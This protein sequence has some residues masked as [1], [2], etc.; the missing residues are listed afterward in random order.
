MSILDNL[1]VSCCI[2]LLRDQSSDW[3]WR[4][5][6]R[7][8]IF[9]CHCE[10]ASRPWQ[11]V[12]PVPAPAGA[13][14]Q[15]LPCVKAAQCSHWVVRRCVAE[16]ATRSVDGGIVVTP[17]LASLCEGGVTAKG[18]DGGRDSVRISLPQS[19]SPTAPSQRGPRNHTSASLA[20]LFAVA[21]ALKCRRSLFYRGRNQRQRRRRRDDPFDRTTKKNFRDRAVQAAENHRA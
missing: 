9:C 7:A 19:A 6:P 20:S 3:S 21:F 1:S 8:R 18:R 16:V 12:S 11:S 17:V 4:F 5:V 13:E 10:G 15:S 14:H 2:L